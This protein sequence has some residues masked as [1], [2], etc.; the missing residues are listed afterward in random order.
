MGDAYGLI[1]SDMQMPVMDGYEAVR[2]IRD[3]GIQTPVVAL[4]A[5]A[6]SGDREK[7]IVAGCDDFLPKPIDRNRL[8]ETCGKYVNVHAPTRT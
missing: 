2:Q 7:C 4:T 6:M 5:C 1:L 8:V 3:A